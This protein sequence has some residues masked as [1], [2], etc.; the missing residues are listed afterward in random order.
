[1]VGIDVDA[2]TLD[3]RLTSDTTAFRAAD[4]IY[5]GL[6]H[7]TPSLEAVPDLAESW[8]TPDP[9]TFIFHLREGL[10]FLGRHAADR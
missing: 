9:Q 10:N 5:S 3:S 8:E 1:M 7:L 6:V 4:L 2:G